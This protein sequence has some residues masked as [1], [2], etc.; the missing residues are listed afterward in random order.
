MR[1][2]RR[3]PSIQSVFRRSFFVI[4]ITSLFIFGMIVYWRFLSITKNETYALLNGERITIESQTD[5]F[6]EENINKLILISAD[7]DIRNALE[8]YRGLKNYQREREARL[9]VIEK[10][11]IPYLNSSGSNVREMILVDSA[12]GDCIL[13]QFNGE[14][15]N[16]P[17]HLT[18]QVFNNTPIARK[19]M[20]KPSSEP[21]S[22]NSRL[23]LVTLAQST[24]IH[25]NSGDIYVLIQY[26]ELTKLVETI[27]KRLT[28]AEKQWT[29]RLFTQNGIPLVL[30]KTTPL[31]LRG[32]SADD[33]V[34]KRAIANI[35]AT[36]QYMKADGTYVIGSFGMMANK[37]AIIVVELPYGFYLTRLTTIG[38]IVLA[39][40]FLITL[41]LVFV[42]SFEARKFSVPVTQLVARCREIAEGDWDRMITISGVR[43]FELLGN[44]FNAMARDLSTSF[45]ERERITRS[46]EETNRLLT[47][48][49][50]EL[51]ESGQRY[52][53][54][55]ERSQDGLFTFNNETGIYTLYNSKFCEILGYSI[56]EMKEITINDVIP[57]EERAY[58]DEQ[59]VLRLRGECV[60]LPY[61]LYVKR[62]DG[63]Y[64]YV[65]VFSRPISNSQLV[66]G[67]I[68]DVTERVMLEKDI[69]E[70]NIQLEQ[71]N[72]SLNSLVHERT[73]TLV[74]LKEIH[75]KIIAN[76]PVGVMVIEQNMTVSFVNDQMAELCLGIA[77]AESLLGI[78]LTDQPDI[79][80]EGMVE[81]VKE[82]LKGE[83][84]HL[85]Q[86][87]FTPQASED[88]LYIDVWA[89]PLLGSDNNIEG[90][91]ILVAD[92][93][94]Q[95]LLR[96][97]LTNSTRLAATGQLAA[98]L[99]HEINN[100]LNSIRYNIELARMDIDDMLKADP[101]V[102]LSSLLEYL[103]II[104]REIDRIGDIV[105]NLLDLHR[106]P[107]SG[108]S[109]IDLN[110]VINDVLILMKKQL[111]ESGVKHQFHSD[112]NIKEVNGVAGQLKQIVLNMMIN[113][114]Q[115]V[116]KN[117][118]IIIR[119][120][121]TDRFSYFSISDNGIGIPE[122]VLPRIFEPF[123]S[124]KGM[125]GVG[126]GLAVCE[127]IVNQFR[128]RIM[129]DSKL[130]EGTT[131]TVYL[132]HYGTDEDQ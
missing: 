116:E 126:L 35:H 99:A 90:A 84:Y 87:K 43:E 91:L 69:I 124:T 60:D 130:G 21:F 132:P 13:D 119:T 128:G 45:R 16:A 19:G 2:Y 10:V 47:I 83:D 38:L 24:P 15:P 103:R 65:E 31:T 77:E 101:N 23:G 54:L 81:R 107:K 111:L 120:G 49:M 131:F 20:S 61:E 29:V 18:G 9:A 110:A 67:S 115:A 88:V 89:V 95:V 25:T 33:M 129:V 48:K 59:R 104:N 37:F 63:E 118:T 106:T 22:Y 12:S 98:S 40:L 62:K 82:C 122:D 58:A 14:T 27:S 30:P 5:Q 44:S 79:L 66:T 105:R 78:A 70:K 4:S 53:D 75:E 32:E 86:V 8:N 39:T 125:S 11:L 108:L 57:P 121:Q 46:L 113:S 72:D 6:V 42:A 56:E 80:P 94:R 17:T 55:Y 73:Q 26:V 64:R 123:F 68:R 3:S 50:A 41:T 96:S 28:D 117:G 52:R 114:I 97:E 92:Q 74:A 34:V 1:D 85:A 7:G 109:N 112:K 100:P 51:E 102:V 36:A 76:V 71:L 93:T 127:S